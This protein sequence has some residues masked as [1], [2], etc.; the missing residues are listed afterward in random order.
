MQKILHQDLKLKNMNKTDHYLRNKN[1]KVIGLKR[2]ELG[3]KTMEEF[4]ALRAKTYSY[5]ID[6]NDEDKKARNT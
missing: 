6:N 2:D 3:G 1:E 5:L 4:A